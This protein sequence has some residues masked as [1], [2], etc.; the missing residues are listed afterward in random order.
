MRGAVKSVG[1]R[2]PA[3]D[4]H[5]FHKKAKEYIPAALRTSLSALIRAIENLTEEIK[6][7]DRLVL[8]MIE[9]RYPQ[10]RVL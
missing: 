6:V 8:E 3:C 2:V 4:A 5:T 1:G 10:A 9:L 7:I